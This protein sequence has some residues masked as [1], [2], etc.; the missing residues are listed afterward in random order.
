MAR[1]QPS[2]VASLSPEAA[3][4]SLSPETSVPSPVAVRSDLARTKMS[5]VASD[6][7][8]TRPLESTAMPHGRKQL[9]GHAERSALLRM[10]FVAVVEVGGSVG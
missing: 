4:E 3:L 2:V 10:S 7:T 6:V 5:P 8:N 1:S 9:R